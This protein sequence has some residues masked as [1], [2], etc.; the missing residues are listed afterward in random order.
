MGFRGR[1]LFGICMSD[2]SLVVVPYE[3]ASNLSL[4]VATVHYKTRFI[5]NNLSNQ[6]GS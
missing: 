3:L 6:T 5:T 2:V 1:P 4:T